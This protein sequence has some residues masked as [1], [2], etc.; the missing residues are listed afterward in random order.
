MS[1]GNGLVVYVAAKSSV[2]EFC[3]DAC[4]YMNAEST[5]NMRNFESIVN[6]LRSY[7]K[8]FSIVLLTP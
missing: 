7:R 6:F 8:H 5:I 1:T 4:R 2:F 3:F